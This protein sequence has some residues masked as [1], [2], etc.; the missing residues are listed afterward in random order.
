MK[1][2]F[3]TIGPGACVL[4]LSLLPPLHAETVLID[5]GNASSYRGA[6]QTGADANGY[7]WTSI[8]S[9]AYYS[10]LV[11]LANNATTLGI[12]FSA[13]TGLGTDSYNGPSGA[14]SIPPAQAEID[15]ANINASSLGILGGSK[16]AAFDFYNAKD[17]RFVVQGLNVNE[18]YNL[19][20][21]GSKK[22]TAGTSTTDYGVYTDSTYATAVGSTSLSV[23][24]V[25][26]GTNNT[27]TTATIAGLT[28]QTSNT[29]YV[30][31]G[32]SAYTANG[33]LNEM[34]I[35]G[36]V[37]YTDGT[38]HTLG[39]A[40]SYP[41]N[42]LLG[43]TTT[44]NANI[45]GA[46]G[47]GTSA[48]QMEAGGGT[49]ALGA[50]QTVLS[51]IGSGNLALSTSANTLTINTGGSTTF[52]VLAGSNGSTVT[53][54][55]A[56]ILSGSGT[57][58]K[59]GSGTQILSGANTFSG[60]V[61]TSAGTLSLNNV[62]ALQNAKLDTLYTGTG[63]VAF[64]IAGTNTYNLGGLAGNKAIAL[65]TN[66]LNVSTATGATVYDGALGG[67]GS[68]TKSGANTLTLRGNNS[69]TGAVTI[70]AGT[71]Q[72]SDDGP[73]GGGTIGSTSGITNNS[74]LVYNLTVN[75]R[76]YANAISGTGTLTKTGG[77]SLTLSGTNSYTGATTI[78]G[79]K[80]AVNGSTNAASAFTVQTGG[81][82][83]GSGAIGGTVGVQSG[84]H[85]APGNSISAT[86]ATGALT[87]ASGSFTDIELG[88]AGTSHAAPG[89][90]DRTA[91]SGSLVLGGTLNVTN[92]A[93]ANGDGSIGAGSYQIF[94]QTGTPTGSFASVVNVAGYH[95]KVDTTTSGSIYLDNYALA[96]AGTIA[97]QDLGKARVGGSFSNSG[98]LGISN[99]TASNSGFSE[100]LNATQGT[101]SGGVI[102]GG[103][104]VSNLAGASSS[105]SLTVGFSTGTSGAKSGSTTIHFASSGSTSGYSDS[106]I[107]SQ[108]V[109]VTGNV[110]D[111]A[112]AVFSLASG[113]A[114][115]TLTPSGNNYILDFGAG[116]ALNT[117]Y[118]ATIQ[119]ANGLLANAF[120]D[121]LR[122]SYGTT[123]DSSRFSSTAG[124]FS[125][126]LSNTGNSFT[127][128]FNTGSAGSFTGGLTLSGYSVQ[129]GL[130][131]A[132]LT[133][134]TLTLAGA[135]IP[136]PDVAVLLGGLGMLAL[137][138]RRC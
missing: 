119:L 66:S 75:D 72:I 100:G 46:L 45:A 76:T 124:T 81:T 125:D 40:K 17:G 15:A 58:S 137:M 133:P 108:T 84:G 19:T 4:A 71:L 102:A 93:G 113:S 31:F 95:A 18:T 67:S 88:T 24:V 98:S 106:A 1:P 130:T 114:A 48:L 12:G 35:V 85:F 30:R 22:Y 43:G 16:A 23:G 105:T 27:G 73:A 82:L 25:A 10:S 36:Y 90:S 126:L 14:T 57:I 54:D 89:T 138:R 109:G 47:G 60:S 34:S 117:N 135:A 9:G 7:S 51:L 86:F 96:T 78:S 50:D 94:T 74:L 77:K 33:Y 92:N 123:G 32:A 79:G 83:G 112:Q 80:L 6:S 21:F 56:G 42:T 64:G 121:N 61:Q 62:N 59:T 2:S 103:S 52:S 63:S 68:L 65:A 20:F 101:V 127:V 26:S 41:G 8:Y 39:S 69:F 13:S 3:R 97:A 110:Y 118:T 70:S 11:D 37:P 111:Y 29:L 38:T 136:E 115:G 131:D 99:A 116:L 107:G 129:S 128:T 134:V 122:G 44:V 5:F 104:N 49:I 91:V 87:L 28:P 53:N 120:Q 132:A 55:Y